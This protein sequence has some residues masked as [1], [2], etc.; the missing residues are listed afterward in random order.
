MSQPRRP[1]GDTA[2]DDEALTLAEDAADIQAAEEARAE[3]RDS[4]ATPIPWE[5]VKVDLGL[6]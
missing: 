6:Q 2:S 5:Q 1:E 3:M 4:G